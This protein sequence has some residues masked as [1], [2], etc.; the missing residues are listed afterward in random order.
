M[1]LLQ[2]T[3]RRRPDPA[4]SIGGLTTTW[5]STPLNPVAHQFLGYVE[6]AYK[7]NGIVFACIT[8]RALL[9]SQI[10]W[11]W[12]DTDDKLTGGPGLR[13]LERPWPGGTGRDLLIRMEQDVSLAGNAYIHRVE[14]NRLRRLRPDWVD[15]VGDADTLEKRGYLYWPGGRLAGKTPEPLGLDDV[16]HYAPIPDPVSPWRG[17]SWISTAIDDVESDELLT[18]HKQRFFQNAATPNLLIKVPGKIANDKAREAYR[19]ELDRTYGGIENAHRTLILDQGADA[20]VIGTNLEQITY[21]AVQ[22]AGENRICVAA[23]VPGIIIGSKEGLSASTYSNYGQAIRAFGN[24]TVDPLWG[25]AA[26]DLEQIVTAPDGQ[27]L[28]YATEH[29]RALREDA[30]DEADVILRKS[31]AAAVLIRVGYETD[32][33]AAAV[34]LPEIPHTGKI[35]VT[36]YQDGE[37]V[38][39]GKESPGD[40]AGEGISN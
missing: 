4:R 26:G 5:A 13:L 3:R 31:N 40:Q 10:R 6:G 14:A 29:I 33:V 2:R 23:G 35:P 25:F 34:G 19:Q 22:A 12:R 16:A 21:T 9:F 37:G 32:K 27:Q 39:D 38:D 24:L 8:A 36:L 18:T 17:M 20:M 7:A 28:W 15:I 11:R 1:N 30:K